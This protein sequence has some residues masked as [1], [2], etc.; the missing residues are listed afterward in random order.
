[1]KE[2]VCIM[3]EYVC[4]MKEYVCS[5]KECV[6]SMKEYFLQY[7]RVCLARVCS[8]YERSMSTV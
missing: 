1:M 4:S 3:K 6:C 7:E 5:M 2:Y 8:Q